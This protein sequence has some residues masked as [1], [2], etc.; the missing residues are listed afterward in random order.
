MMCSYLDPRSFVQVQVT[1][2]MVKFLSMQFPSMK[3]NWK[4]QLDKNIASD[5]ELYPDL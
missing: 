5:M 4:L 3:N 2:K 1:V